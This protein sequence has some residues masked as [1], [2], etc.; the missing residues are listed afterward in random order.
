MYNNNIIILY[1]F[2]VRAYELPM[3]KKFNQTN[4]IT[5]QT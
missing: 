3:Y 1:T 5:T 2:F 4:E